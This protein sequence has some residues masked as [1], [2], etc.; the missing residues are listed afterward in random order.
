MLFV[1][2]NKIVGFECIWV[3]DE[4]FGKDEWGFLVCIFKMM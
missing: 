1:D 2:F 4:W 3:L